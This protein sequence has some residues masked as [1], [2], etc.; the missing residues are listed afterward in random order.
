MLRTNQYHLLGAQ[1]YFLIQFRK[2]PGTPARRQEQWH[3]VFLLPYLYEEETGCW[4]WVMVHVDGHEDGCSHHQHQHEDADDE[5]GVERSSFL[6]CCTVICWGC[7]ESTPL[8][9]VTNALHIPSHRWKRNICFFCVTYTSFPTAQVGKKILAV[10]FLQLGTL[11][12]LMK[13]LS[14]VLLILIP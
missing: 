4:C 10:S 7:T 1:R 5:A 6:L 9:T 2:I 12:N 11:I 14:N 3:S 13:R 8:S